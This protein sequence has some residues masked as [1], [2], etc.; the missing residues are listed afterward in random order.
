MLQFSFYRVK[1]Q[2]CPKEFMNESFVL[3]VGMK[4][5]LRDER[6]RALPKFLS[7]LLFN[8]IDVCSVHLK[9]YLPLIAGVDQHL[10]GLCYF[11]SFI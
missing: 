8:A 9:R 1:L 11:K 3:L 6:S 5:Y 7:V 2:F 10:L 4:T